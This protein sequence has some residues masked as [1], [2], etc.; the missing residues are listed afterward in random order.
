MTD[1]QWYFAYGSNLFVEQKERRTGHIRKAIRCRLPDY[2]LAF[3]KL[4]RKGNVYANIVPERTEEV[5]GVIYLCGREALKKMD[6]CEGVYS[7][8]YRRVEV[9]VL[10]E[11]DQSVSAYTYVA[12]EDYV[13]CTPLSRQN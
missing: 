8:H 5:W 10:T 13:K 3:N 2:R 9:V 1:I 4:G 6:I 11:S 12:G 7:G